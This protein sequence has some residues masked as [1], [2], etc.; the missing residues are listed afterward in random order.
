MAPAITCGSRGSS[1]VDNRIARC[2]NGNCR[3]RAGEAGDTAALPFST[4]R[5]RTSCS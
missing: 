1:P 5:A 2:E 3:G 4:V